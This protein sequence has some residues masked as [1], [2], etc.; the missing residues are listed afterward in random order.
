MLITNTYDLI[1][2]RKNDLAMTWTDIA[3]KM[4]ILHMQNAM[5]AARR[6]TLPDNFVKLA[7]ALDCD[8]EVR[9]VPRKVEVPE[10]FY[11]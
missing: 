6:G 1:Q 10:D 3:E 2:A 4:G 5:D 8:I 7:E 11:S 9:L